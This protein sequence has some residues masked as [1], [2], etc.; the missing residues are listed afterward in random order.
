[1]LDFRQIRDLF[2]LR[3]KILQFGYGITIPHAASRH[4]LG[5]QIVPIAL[6]R[7]SARQEA[8]IL[9]AEAKTPRFTFGISKV[10]K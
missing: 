8:N 6:Q 2:L 7:V 1:M 5:I 10:A 9:L 4:T 3:R